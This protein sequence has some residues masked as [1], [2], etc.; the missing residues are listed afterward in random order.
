MSGS[1]N[2]LLVDIPSYMQNDTTEFAAAV[3]GFIAAAEDKIYRDLTTQA[4][5]TS[6]T[7]TFTAGNGVFTRPS[8]LSSPR[9]F[10]ITVAG[11]QVRLDFKRLE[12]ILQYAP[13]STQGVPRYYAVL[14]N[15]QYR[16]APLP[17]GTYAWTLFYN[18]KL[19]S[20]GPANQTNWVTDNAYDLILAGSLAQAARWT[21]DDRQASLV[22]FWDGQYK[23]I[24]TNVNRVETRADRDSA[25][26]ILYPQENR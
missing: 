4:L 26:P 8:D 14:N 5:E 21:Q 17:D 6:T 18:R 12:Y 16:V 22:A 23:E 7:G 3:P 11:E 9:S 1:Y 25:R 20:L 2:Q 15:T 24:A 10:Y 13:G 19:A